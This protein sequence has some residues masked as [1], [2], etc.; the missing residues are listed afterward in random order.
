L[1]AASGILECNYSQPR[2]L[3]AVKPRNERQGAASH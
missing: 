3:N 1:P 2:V